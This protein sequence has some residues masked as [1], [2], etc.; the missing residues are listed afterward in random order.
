MG[1][2]ASSLCLAP[3]LLPALAI[4]AEP[5]GQ[6]PYEMVW[7]GRTEDTHPALVDFE[8]IEGWTVECEQAEATFTRSRQ[9]QLW[10]EHVG[11]LVYRG[12]G[13][14]A[15]VTLKP[16]QPVP[17]KG[18]FDCLN[19]WVYGNNWAWVP[20][21]TT[22]QVEVRV[23]LRGRGGLVRAAMGR[24][25][26][27]E[28]WVMHRRLRPDEL[29]L[30]EDGATFE[31]LEVAGGRNEEDRRLHFDNLAAYQEPLPP[32]EFEPRSKRG[33]DL[34]PGQTTGTNTG[35]GRLPFPNREETILPD[36]LTDRFQVSLESTG[37]EFLF[38]YR[39]DD[40]HLVYRYKPEKGTLGD[41]SAQWEGTSG[42]FQPTAEGGVYFWSDD[43]AGAVPPE[44]IELDECVQEGDAVVSKWRCTLGERIAEATY[45]L[46]LWQKS[47]VVDVKCPGGHVGEFRT[48]K[49]VGVENP[50]LVTLPYLVGDQERPAIL[51]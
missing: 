21:R 24:V 45:T 2:K 18:P 6:R 42:E 38:H 50:R 3:L 37:G 44:K 20:D 33:I 35:P 25:R 17:I 12:T 31:G 11:T 13:P 9:E 36:N 48:G 43:S 40:G 27:R 14:G 46:R 32:L 7:A 30:V 5:V 23:L 41:V 4:G 26:W 47:L 19:F 16:P 15:T 1:S 39:G 22:P 49:A 29:A 8:N 34:P 10:G 51:V 28:W